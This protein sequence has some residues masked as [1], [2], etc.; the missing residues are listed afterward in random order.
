MVMQ[1]T[2]GAM[3]SSAMIWRNEMNDVMKRMGD[4]RLSPGDLGGWVRFYKGR[5]SSDKEKATFR[6]N[7]TPSKPV[8]TGKR[9][10]IGGSASPEA[11]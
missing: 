7:Y 4:L 9:G 8:T 6:M 11:T 3:T 1:S 5:T 10:R 2:K